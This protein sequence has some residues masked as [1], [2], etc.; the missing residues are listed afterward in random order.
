MNGP[1]AIRS[2]N[3]AR[4]LDTASAP[5]ARASRAGKASAATNVTA[6]GAVKRM[7]CARREGVFARARTC[8]GMTARSPIVEQMRAVDMADVRSLRR[9]PCYQ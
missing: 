8:T 1:P 5:A 9:L 3:T 6:Q 2:V 7:E 4:A